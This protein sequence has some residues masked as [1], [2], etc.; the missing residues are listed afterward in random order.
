MSCTLWVLYFEDAPEVVMGLGTAAQLPELRGRPVPPLMFVD[1]LR[2]SRS[3]ARARGHSSTR[4]RDTLT[5]G[6]CA[7]ASRRPR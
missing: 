5:A 1:D 2:W 6:T 3:R 4:S 7:T